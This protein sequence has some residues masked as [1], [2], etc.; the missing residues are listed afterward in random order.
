MKTTYLTKPLPPCSKSSNEL[1]LLKLLLLLGWITLGSPGYKYCTSCPF[2]ERP[3]SSVV[4]PN[5]LAVAGVNP[6]A[7]VM[8]LEP[9]NDCKSDRSGI[10]SSGGTKTVDAEPDPERALVALSMDPIV[11]IEPVGDRVIER[12][13]SVTLRSSASL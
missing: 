2:A 4:R 3:P 6:V 10:T 5:P 12:S 7:R 8:P 11:L 1:V 9:D 13:G